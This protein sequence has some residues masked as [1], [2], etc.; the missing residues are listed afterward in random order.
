MCISWFKITLYANKLQLVL[1]ITT[2]YSE[3]S[4]MTHVLDKLVESSSHRHFPTPTVIT[5]KYLYDKCYT[6]L[7]I[8]KHAS[9]KINH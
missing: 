6:V 5:L 3:I 7:L 8:A 1:T 9:M 4:E 2:H